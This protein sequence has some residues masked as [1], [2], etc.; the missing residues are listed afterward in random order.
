MDPVVS[1]RFGLLMTL[2]DDGFMWFAIANLTG[3]S[4]Y[5]VFKVQARQEPHTSCGFPAV[6][7]RPNLGGEEVLY[8]FPRPVSTTIL[9]FL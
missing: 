6:V 3:L 7:R 1:I 9:R 4:Q 5:P 8:S 2:S